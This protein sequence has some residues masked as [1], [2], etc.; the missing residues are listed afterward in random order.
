MGQSL[1]R[2]AQLLRIS[3]SQNIDLVKLLVEENAVNIHMVLLA[4][5]ITMNYLRLAM[6]GER[7][8]SH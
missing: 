7:H 2:L 3:L 4:F 1:V 8:S 6:I 5:I